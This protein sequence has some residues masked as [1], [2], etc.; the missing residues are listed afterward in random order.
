MYITAH[1]SAINVGVANLNVK[2]PCVGHRF[3]ISPPDMTVFCPYGPGVL[4][5]YIDRCI[6]SWTGYKSLINERSYMRLVNFRLYI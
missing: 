6:K 1:S 4:G 3:L 5:H 2:I